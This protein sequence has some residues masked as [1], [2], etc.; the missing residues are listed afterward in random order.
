MK[1]CL[2]ILT[3]F[4]ISLTF[5][6]CGII[7]SGG[8]TNHVRY[9][10][11]TKIYLI[12]ADGSNI[13]FLA[14]GSKPKFSKDGS[15]IYFSQGDS[16]YSINSTGTNQ[17][18][19]FSSSQPIWDYA[20][21]NDGKYIAVSTFYNF[22]FLKSDGTFNQQLASETSG[23]FDENESFSTNDSLIIYQ[24]YFGISTIIPN[25]SNQKDLFIQDSAHEYYEPAFIPNSKSFLYTFM[26][27]YKQCFIRLSSLDNLSYTNIYSYYGFHD[28][29]TGREDIKLS[30][31]DDI[32]FPDKADQN[33]TTFYIHKIN[34]NSIHD[35]ILTDGYD[36]NYSSDFSKVT[37]LKP[38]DGTKSI[39]IYDLQ[40]S[41]IST[42]KTNLSWANL[43][44]PQLNNSQILFEAD[45][46]YVDG[47]F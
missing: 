23:K 28:F 17:K 31:N 37:Y 47:T 18:L 40:S 24:R 25:G 19:L 39:Y 12:Y 44:H 21:S 27:Y 30:P 6:S 20:I 32:L 1:Y 35:N 14:Y 4:S 7:D 42:I 43:Y 8:G 22:Y 26:D 45:S 38:N 11:K 9:S 3:L 15:T 36:V 5:F 2:S 41:A 10:A 13:K 16:L 34:L 46:I 33:G 29:T